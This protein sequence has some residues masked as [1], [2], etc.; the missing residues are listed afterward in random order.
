VAR[1]PTT[2]SDTGVWGDILNDF[3]L[4]SH[5]SSGT[6]KPLVSDLDLN[7]YKVTNL[8]DPASSQDAATKHYVDTASPVLSVA[9]KT[10]DVS[11][12]KSDVG[13]SNVDNTSDANKPVSTAQQTALDAKLTRAGDTMT[14][15]LAEAVIA[16][17]DGS[18]IN[19]DA[20]LGNI[21]T[22]TLGGDRTIADPTNPTSGQKII[23]RLKQD[24]TGSRVVSWGNAYKFG[25]DVVQP[26]LST[27]G[28]KV[29]YLAFI[30]N[31]GSSQWDCLATARGY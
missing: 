4:V 27:T 30:Y 18:T 9:S 14:G 19:I 23:I 16:L 15:K 13:L 11:L 8:S 2:G 29:D 1:L 17:T 6:L 31:A 26:T 12:T 10:G 21:F 25:L 22:V 24:G 7:N 5:T 3:L 28:G 20:S